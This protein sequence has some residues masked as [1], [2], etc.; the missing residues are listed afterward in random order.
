MFFQGNDTKEQ[1]NMD[2]RYLKLYHDKIKK[3]RED[4]NQ[5][6]FAHQWAKRKARVAKDM[7]RKLEEMKLK[8]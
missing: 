1:R 8:P 5:I 4:M 6:D 7:Q 2:L 3:Q